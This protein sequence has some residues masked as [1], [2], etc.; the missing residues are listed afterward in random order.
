MDLRE[1]HPILILLTNLIPILSMLS[2]IMHLGIIQ[3]W[4]TKYTDHLYTSVDP[5]VY[6][7]WSQWF[8]AIA[9]LMLTPVS[10]F[11]QVN[12]RTS[13]NN[14]PLRLIFQV[15]TSTETKC[16]ATTS[17]SSLLSFPWM[18]THNCLTLTVPHHDNA[19]SRYVCR[20]VLL[21]HKPTW[22]KIHLNQQV[23][24]LPWHH[25]SM[26]TLYL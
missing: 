8:A 11:K 19:T 26:P 12:W 9:Y 4:I 2:Q 14:K 15:Q 3:G 5:Q 25:G 22:K 17:L 23:L 18:M 21:S 6:T 1:P 13:H 20:V 16:L 7:T 24:L 10:P